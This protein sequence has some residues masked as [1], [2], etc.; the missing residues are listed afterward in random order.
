GEYCCE[1]HSVG[2]FVAGRVNDPRSHV[3]GTPSGTTVRAVAHVAVNA[4][5]LLVTQPQTRVTPTSDI[6]ITSVSVVPSGAG[7]FTSESGPF[8]AISAR[9]EPAQLGRYAI[10]SRLLDRRL[11]E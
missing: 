2:V 3:P 10:A 11:P 8:S 4:P 1:A 7:R 6:R 5:R 9:W